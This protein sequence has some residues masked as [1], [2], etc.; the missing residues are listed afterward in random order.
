MGDFIGSTLFFV[1][2]GVI[3]IALVGV[4]IYLRKKGEED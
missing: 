3:L 2:L 4:F 1:I